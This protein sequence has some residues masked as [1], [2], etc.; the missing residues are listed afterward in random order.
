MAQAL[1]VA[2]IASIA[3]AVVLLASRWL[4]AGQSNMEMS[5]NSLNSFQDED[6]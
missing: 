5:V 2:R 3:A 4:A 6:P 1:G